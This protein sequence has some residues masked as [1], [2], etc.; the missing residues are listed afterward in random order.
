MTELLAAAFSAIAA[1]L[2]WINKRNTKTSN[3]KTLAALVER[4]DQNVSVLQTA[5]TSHVADADL[6]FKNQVEHYAQEAA[7]AAG[8]EEVHNG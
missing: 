6:H 7:D 1:L 2:S 8:R 3:G 4:T 5:F